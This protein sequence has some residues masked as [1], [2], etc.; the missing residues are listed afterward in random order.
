MRVCES[1]ICG[2]LAGYGMMPW[3]E[4]MTS[5][6]WVILEI[7]LLE[8]KRQKGTAWVGGKGTKGAAC[9]VKT[10]GSRQASGNIAR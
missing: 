4:T 1:A 7:A 10:G 3:H 5:L 9:W 6:D 2:G 8:A